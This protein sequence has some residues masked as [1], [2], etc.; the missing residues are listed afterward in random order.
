MKKVTTEL[1]SEVPYVWRKH[2]SFHFPIKDGKKTRLNISNALYVTKY[3]EY[4]N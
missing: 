2:L 4:S 1:F 3:N